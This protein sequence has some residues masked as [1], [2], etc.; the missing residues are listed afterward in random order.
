MAVSRCAVRCA[1]VV[2]RF[3]GVLASHWLHRAIT[4]VRALSE[5]A[6]LSYPSTAG[7]TRHA[8]TA[9]SRTRA[10]RAAGLRRGASPART[11]APCGG[12]EALC[13]GARG[14]PRPLRRAAN[15]RRGLVCQGRTRRG[16]AAHLAG[17]E[18]APSLAADPAL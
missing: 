2:Q 12:G 3:A 10:Q 7:N 5:S 15:A 14:A 11:G 4:A 13:G 16:I 1:P 17:D 6:G 8:A 18:A 9:A